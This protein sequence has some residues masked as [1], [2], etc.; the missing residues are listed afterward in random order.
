MLK[1]GTPDQILA[2]YNRL[3]GEVTA[4]LNSIVQLTYFMRGGM[5]YDHILYGMSYI[6]REIAFDYV[7][8]RLEMEM[9]SPHPVY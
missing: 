4:I 8:K 5:K 9:K 3:N 1:N 6:E 2:M 7:S